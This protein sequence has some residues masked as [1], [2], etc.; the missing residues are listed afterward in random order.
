MSHTDSFIDEV[1]EEV[2][3]DRLFLMLKRYGWIGA[4]GVVL[5]VGGAVWREYSRAQAQAQAQ[6]VGDAISSAMSANDAAARA[7][8]LGAVDA[9]SAGAEAVVALARAA[10]LAEEGAR[11]EAVA[12]LERVASNGDVARIYRDIA[13]F[14]AV[15]LAGDEMAREDRELRLQALAEPGAPLQYLAQEQLALLDIAAGDTEAALARLGDIWRAADA[16]QDLKDRVSQVIVA[17][18]GDP[19]TLS[20]EG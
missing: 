7:E 20:Q 12:L 2:R 9:P 1:T 14:K 15:T 11:S 10:A 17:L 16:P 3:R 19:Q 8:A 4:V 13:A 18:G 6:A 5:L